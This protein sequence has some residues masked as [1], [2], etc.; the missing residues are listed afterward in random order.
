VFAGLMFNFQ[1]I[2]AFL[3][4]NSFVHAIRFKRFSIENFRCYYLNC[5]IL[6]YTLF[7]KQAAIA[8]AV[9]ENKSPSAC[10]LMHALVTGH[11]TATLP[12]KLTK[13]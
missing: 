11:V 6:Y 8:F 2:K 10:F 9:F 5:I 3:A 4:I 1:H 12:E 7:T 13:S